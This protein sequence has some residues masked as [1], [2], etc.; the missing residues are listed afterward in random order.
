SELHQL[1]ARKHELRLKRAEIDGK[2]QSVRERLRG[3]QERASRARQEVERR[4]LAVEQA[5]EEAELARQARAAFLG[6]DHSSGSLGNEIQGAQQQLERVRGE[7]RKSDERLH[8]VKLELA[9]SASELETLERRISLASGG[10]DA[11]H[12]PERLQSL[13]DERLLTRLDVQHAVDLSVRPALRAALGAVYSWFALAEGEH[14]NQL[15]IAFG[16]LEAD[17]AVVFPQS[18]SFQPL[19]LP[20]GA[21]GEAVALLQMLPESAR[22]SVAGVLSA[23]FLV[24]TLDDALLLREWAATSLNAADYERLLIVT[25]GGDVVRAWGLYS[26]A[27]GEGLNNAPELAERLRAAEAALRDERSSLEAE[28]ERLHGEEASLAENL[29]ELMRREADLRKKEQSGR[30]ELN[31]LIARIAHHEG[32]EQFEQNAIESLEEELVGIESR[33]RELA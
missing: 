22:R 19:E 2:L 21:P 29:N 30:E 20:A 25:R 17:V 4:S 16:E 26:T 8:Q 6:V 5:K 12:T 10:S 24:P 9:R 27:R 3:L 28:R 33:Q 7:R 23:A 31:R 18:A 11:A 14:F 32:Q 15:S 1:T 13:V